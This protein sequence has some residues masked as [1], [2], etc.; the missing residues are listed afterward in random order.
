VLRHFTKL[1][2]GGFWVIVLKLQKEI[3]RTV[4]RRRFYERQNYDI[5][6]PKESIKT[7]KN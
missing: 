2:I 5:E 3:K 1:K 7:K 6:S 4:K